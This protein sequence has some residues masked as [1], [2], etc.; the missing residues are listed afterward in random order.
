MSI[1]NCYN[2]VKMHF[3]THQIALFKKISGNDATPL[4]LLKI[5]PHTPCLNMYGCTSSR[6][7][8]NVCKSLCKQCN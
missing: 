7:M 5:T 3:K 2:Y 6:V 1:V 8:L 4:I